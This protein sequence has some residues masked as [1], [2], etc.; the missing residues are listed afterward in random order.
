VTVVRFTWTVGWVD[1]WI[2]DVR[3]YRSLK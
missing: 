1:Y 2:D 3:F